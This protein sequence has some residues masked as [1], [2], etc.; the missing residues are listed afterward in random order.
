MKDRK[1]NMTEYMRKWRAKNR[2]RWNELAR[3]RAKTVK[4]IQQDNKDKD[5]FL[6]TKTNFFVKDG[7]R[8]FIHRK[9]NKFYYEIFFNDFR[10]HYVSQEF[11]SRLSLNKDLFYAI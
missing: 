9:G 11:G 7:H 10:K 4:E 6:Q 8:V 5:C 3:Q 2:E 1:I